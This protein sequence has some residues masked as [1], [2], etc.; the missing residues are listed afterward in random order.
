MQDYPS[1]FVCQVPTI[2]WNML[3]P[4][5]NT[6]DTHIELEVCVTMIEEERPPRAQ[7]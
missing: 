1:F 4:L 7:M 2:P 6:E 3:V 5:E